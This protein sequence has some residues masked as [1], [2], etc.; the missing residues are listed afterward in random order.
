MNNKK[1]TYVATTIYHLYLSILHL[2]KDA[3]YTE[4]Y[5]ENLLFLIET[6]PGIEVLIPALKQH[7][8]KEVHIL[9]KKKTHKKELGK[10]N[11][12]LRRKST[13]IPYLEKKHPCLAN[14][15][16]FILASDVYLCE[17]DSSKSYFYYLCSNK[18]MSMIED[19]A[20]TY[21]KNHSKLE[22]LY[23][24]FL[25]NT[26]LAG[27]YNKEITAVLAQYPDK[28]PAELKQKAVELNINKELPLLKEEHKNSIFNLFLFN[29]PLNISHDKKKVLVLTQP[30]S[31][32]NI[33]ASEAVKIKIYKDLIDKIPK[34]YQ[35]I[36]KTHPREKT[37]YSLHFNTALVLPKL[38]PIELLDLKDNFEF[39]KGYTL[40]STAL[41]NLKRIKERHYMGI[42]YLDYFASKAIKKLIL[43]T[44][45]S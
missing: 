3:N 37:D 26:P 19:G 33:V 9:S 24:T 20:R 4:T 45:K 18:G 25:T 15:K 36:I 16:A 30:I 7:F 21:I 32:D 8:F 43:H 40:F 44:N 22:Y 23:K 31:E 1:R 5:G 11:Y 39:E 28:L 17:T 29:T 42:D 2:I 38:F 27:G 34:E 14:E 35:I 13:L 41:E 6:T 10:F 12:G